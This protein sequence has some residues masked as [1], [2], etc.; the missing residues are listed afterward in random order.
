MQTGQRH[1]ISLI[2][3]GIVTLLRRLSLW[4]LLAGSV[5]L[6]ILAFLAA[7]FGI[8]FALGRRSSNAA[9]DIALIQACLNIPVAIASIWG[10][11]GAVEIVKQFIPQPN[12]DHKSSANDKNQPAQVRLSSGDD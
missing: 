2:W 11:F 12:N 4:E 1:L 6:S 5:T 3:T 7:L 9:D 8:G 10:V